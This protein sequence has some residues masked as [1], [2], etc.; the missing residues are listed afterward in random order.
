M[1]HFKSSKAD[2]WGRYAGAL[3]Y[4]VCHRSTLNQHRYHPCFLQNALVSTTES[5][6]AISHS[7]KQ[8]PSAKSQIVV[9]FQ[10][11]CGVTYILSKGG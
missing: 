11:S 10:P 2:V 5:F 9:F 7:P 1:I 3:E 6:H 8:T 4:I